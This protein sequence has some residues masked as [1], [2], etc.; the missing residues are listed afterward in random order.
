MDRLF[1]EHRAPTT[2]G[3]HLRAYSFGN[4]RQVDAVASR[5]LVNLA[6]LVPGLRPR[7]PDIGG[8]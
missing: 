4:V 1:D 3:T 8:P 2:L 6:G 7:T 5:A